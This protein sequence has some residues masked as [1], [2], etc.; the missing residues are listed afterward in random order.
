M[1]DQ[2][3]GNA[4]F[5]IER[6]GSD[7]IPER[8]RRMTVRDLA[9]FWT[10]TNLYF[11][12][13][14]I[15]VIAYSF[16]AQLWQTLL[17]VAAGN[18]AYVL[19]A[20]GSVPGARC[21]LPTL[22]I[23][24][25][26][27]GRDA[28]RVNSLFS[29]ILG[30]CFEAVNVVFGVFAVI[31]LLA[32]VGWED[33]GTAGKLVGLAVVYVS[34]VVVS[35]LGH[36][37]VVWM[38]RLFAI[39]LAVVMVV[40]AAWTVGGVDLGA[41]AGEPLGGS[42]TVGVML[43]AAGV[44]A[45]AGLAY[46]QIPSDYTRYLPSGTSGPRIFWPVLA[47]AGGAALFLSLLGALLASRADLAD[48]VA[49]LEALV[50]GWLYLP[51]LLA[52]I[53][54]SVGNNVITLYSAAFAVQ[55]L[56]IGLKRYQAT[57]LDGAVSTLLIVYVLFIDE[58]FLSTLNDFISIVVVW[59]A[60]FGAIWIADALLRRSRFDD[61]AGLPA[62]NVRGAVALLAGAGTCLLTMNAPVLQGPLSAGLLADGD[63]AW[64]LGPIV[65]AGVYVALSLRRLRGAPEAPAPE[66]I[67]APV[68]EQVR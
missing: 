28:N 4:R 64:L 49:G 56:G 59:I 18:A 15:G 46:L 68:L 22:A 1:D 20:L 37:T 67:P 2:A 63:L 39:G 11:F 3:E 30:V 53:G 9:L 12:N 36:A 42:A 35:I 48:P 6:H 38:Q 55:T 17:A 13:F 29:W 57:A 32:F 23:S 21:G 51:F 52:V 44:V 66:P 50:P 19:V 62:V 8:E 5:R 27:F 60:P 7:R 65:G 33:T 43:L 40:V 58:N 47:A 61:A 25:S 14:V 45:G 26:A 31:A 41:R 34:S 16:G 24:R 54:G 10:A